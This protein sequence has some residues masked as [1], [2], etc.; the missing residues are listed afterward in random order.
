MRALSEVD[1]VAA[2]L[3]PRLLGDPSGMQ[4][5]VMD[6]GATWLSCRVPLADGSHREVL[7][8]C[9]T[10]APR[11]GFMGA[12]IG[13][14]ANRIA[15]GRISRNERSWALSLGP[16]ERHQLHGGPGGFHTRDWHLLEHRSDRIRWELVSPEGDQGFPG[17]MK[18]SLSIQLSGEG[19]I[20]WICRAT[21]SE[22][23]PIAITN[24]A[25]FNLDGHGRVLDHRLMIAASHFAPI[26]AELI[27]LTR[28]R[29]TANSD[30][31][32][33]TAT[34][35]SARWLDSDQQLLAGGY[36]HGFLLER[37]CGPGLAPAA[38][39][40]SSDGA[41]SMEISTTAPALQ[42][43][44]GQ[45]LEGVLDAKGARLPACA[46][47]ALEPGFIADSPNRAAWPQPSCWVA[48]NQTY[49]HKIR[50]SFHTR[51]PR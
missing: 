19:V 18:V 6:R 45:H 44:T 1:P 33:S 20:D 3:R 49:E 5:T 9:A 7:L 27:P 43:Y 34:R 29:P 11:S 10:R 24:H 30:F 48:P 28:L 31:D 21:V 38:L 2:G 13:R 51:A 17:V 47:V 22:S 39:L 36:D 37:Q 32:F 25:Y 46:G 14:Y 12:T 8:D 40:E 42:V 15:R 16:N 41:L 23:C 4:L 26:D 50:Y 35:L